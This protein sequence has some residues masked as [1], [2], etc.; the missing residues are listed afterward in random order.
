M[1]LAVLACWSIALPRVAAAYR[2]LPIKGVG[3]IGPNVLNLAP[4]TTGCRN[5]TY[6]SSVGFPFRNRSLVVDLGAPVLVHRLML[7]DDFSDHG[8]TSPVIAKHGLLI[9]TSNDDQTYTR[10]TAPVAISFRSGKPE[11]AFDVVEI[12]GLAM[13]ARYVK[14]HQQLPDDEWD[15]ANKDLQKMVRAYQNPDL[16]AAIDYVV[17]PRY[18]CGR[19]ALRAKIAM[20]R[21]SAPG[22][23]LEVRDEAEELVAKLPVPASGMCVGEVDV[24]RLSQGLHSLRVRALLAAGVPVAGATLQTY[25]CA[26]IATNPP[27]P[28]QSEP[29]QVVM[30]SELE[31]HAPAQWQTRTFVRV[32][33]TT[34]RPLLE[35]EFGAPTLKLKLA[36]TGW[37]AVSIGVIGDTEVDARLGEHGTWRRCRLEVWRQ[38]DRAEGLGEAFAGCADLHDTTL[39]LRPLRAKPCRVAFVRLV[40]LSAEQVRLVLAAR[41]PNT[42]KRVTINNDGFSMFFGGVNSVE[43]IHSMIDKYA[44]KM[45][46][47]YDYGLGTDCSC[48]YDTK[49]GTVFGTLEKE[50]W[51]QGDQRAYEGIQ[52][53]IREGND[54]LRVLIERCHEKGIRVHTSFR[55]NA[56]YPL[57]AG[58]NFN[59]AHYWRCHDTCRI[60]TRYGKLSNNLS[61]AHP[62]VRAYRLAIIRE[63]ATYA[64]DGMHLDFL[65]HPPF[66]GND[67]PIN[68]AFKQR[69]GEEPPAKPFDDERWETVRAEVMTQ[70]MGDVRKA[71]DEVGANLGRRLP[72]SA[73]FD[74]MAYN[75]HGLDVKRWIDE[76]LVDNISPG[77]HGFGGTRFAIDDFVAMTRGTP[78]KLF[79]RLEHIIQGHD[80]TPESERGEVVFKSERMTVN[81]YRA[82]VLELYDRGADGVYLFNTGGNRLLDTISDEP[83]LRAWNAVERPVVGWLDAVR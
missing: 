4:E 32:G 42:R 75:A 16:A 41:K 17:A 58:K 55:M 52:K 13:V 5:F 2:E 38:H 44:D 60:V 56:C 80:P 53:L 22:I 36:A 23:T 79:V 57:P 74:C 51:R 50:H 11:G 12:D 14:L 82:R 19:A 49:A 3:Y 29:G 62:E 77:V 40:G 73:S 72:V 81:R 15:L 45:L 20:P 67:K 61:Y 21:T 24:T 66:T 27:Q 8:G 26:G 63:A 6:R 37:H 47:S 64:P 33:D 10:Y 68:D 35:A 39:Y 70:F 43:Q 69:Y 76:G 18:V 71:M 59:G 34:P 31:P 1:C 25:V 28:V 30:L 48:T 9:Y 54:P 65:R 83:G 78:C 46:Y 7:I